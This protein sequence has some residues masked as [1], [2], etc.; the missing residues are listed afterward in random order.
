[1][2][3]LRV[4]IVD[5]SLTVRSRLAEVLGASDDMCVVGAVGDGQSAVEACATLRP[6]AITMDMMLPGMNG[7]QATEHIM[8]HFPTP[9]LVVSSSFNRGELFKT[10]DALAAGAVN[11]LEK[12][13]G[14]EP[15]GAWEARLLA[16]LRL[17]SRVRVITHV[18]A[19]LG[20]PRASP[21]PVVNLGWAGSSLR[22]R[23]IALGA[24]T[25]GP[26]ALVRVVGALPRE[27][28]VPILIVLHLAAPF[29]GAFAEWFGAQTQRSVRYAA[30]GERLAELDHQVILAPPD[31]HLVVRDGALAL[32]LDPER[33][34]CRP[35]VNVLFESLAAELGA[36]VAACLLTGMG[37]DGALGLL[38]LRRAGSFTLAQDEATSSV[39]GMPR[40]A[41]LLAAAARVLSLDAVAPALAGWLS[42]AAGRAR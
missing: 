1:M 11:V 30:G 32:T 8:A 41:A 15:E 12:P 27:D 37:K 20:T 34:S 14:D 23:A 9:I 26:A 39:Y 16:S 31:R 2:S 7:L 6:D 40:E 19:R 36:G 10:Y 35:S 4:L 3:A 28:P 13:A 18:R 17:V 33:H 38:A 42:V 21:S 24:S 29:A 22:R 5:D 25:G